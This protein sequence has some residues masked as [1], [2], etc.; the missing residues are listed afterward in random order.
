[1]RVFKHINNLLH[2]DLGSART[3]AGRALLIEQF[4]VLTGQIPVLYGVLIVE[5]LSVS[6]VLPSSLPLWFRFGVPSA[7]LVVSA[8]RMIY[9]IK[10]RRVVPTPERALR[11]LFKTRILASA[12]NACFSIWTLLLFD[13]VDPGSRAPLALLVFMGSIGSAYCLASFPSAARLTLALTALPISLR[14]LFADD[15]LSV[16]IGINNCMLLVPFFR[17]MN[18]NYCD[19]VD[20]IESRTM[21]L[22]EGDRARNA[23]KTARE[24]QANARRIAERFDIAL[25]N[26]S[27]GLCF[28][29]GE[30]R[31]VVCNRR[32]LD[33]YGLAPESVKPGMLLAEIVEL[34]SRA[35]SSPVMSA[36]D[37]MAWRNRIADVNEAS[38][39]IVELADGRVFRICHRPM[40]DHGW[41]ATH[42]DITEQHRAEK[43]L[44]EAKANAERAELTARSAHTRL[45]EAL[46]IVPEGIAILDADDRYVM[47]NKRYAELYADSSQAIIAGMSFEEVLRFG[48]A[49]QQYPDA[50][51]R[52]EEW[53]IE[54]LTRHAQPWS[55]HEQHLSGDRWLRIEERRMEDGG[56]IG[57]RVDITDLKRR[58]A[59]FR[60]LFEENPLPMWVVDVETLQFLAVNA[61]ACQHYGYSPEQM[62]TMTVED[63]RAP[64]ERRML[65]D[66]FRRHGGLHTAKQTRHHVTA[67]GRAIEV[68]IEARPLR[69]N[70]RNAS[71]AV[72]F[73]MTDRKR[74]EQR[75]LH[76][77]CHDILTDL[78]N[79]AALD[80]R[81]A[82]VLQEA[83][84]RGTGF[85]VLCIDLDRF[86]QINDLFG[87]S[88]GDQALREVS[89]RLLAAAQGA[90][91]ARVGGDE[92]IAITDQAPLPSSAELLAKR[93]REALESGILIE[94]HTLELDLSV[95]VAVYPRDGDNA[96]LL[97]ANA[98]AALYRAKAEGRGVIR[99]FSAAMDQ[100]L[101][102]RRALERDLK[103]AVRSGELFLEYQPQRHR[104]G[105][106]IGFEALVRWQHPRHGVIPPTEFISIAEE[107]DLIVEIGD[108]VLREACRR[109]A[110]WDDHLR[111]AVNVSAIQFRRGN[112]Q[113]AVA[114]ALQEAGISPERLELEITESLLIEN[115]A[116]TTQM[117]KGLKKL[118]TRIAL[119]DFGT[120]Y[121]SLSYLQSFPLDRIKIDRSFVATLG[122]A[123]RSLAIVRA[124]I[125]LAH[126]LGLP[127]LA[128]GVETG[129]QLE[130]LIEEGCDEMQGF[131]IGRP[132]RTEAYANLLRRDSAVARV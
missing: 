28:Y 7:L 112:L 84:A 85:A 96:R 71:V 43:A 95:G 29:D 24:E 41:V 38:D 68:A 83:R 99:F 114:M 5:S 47:W 124:V 17:M 87:H 113:R 55:R 102:E 56:S 105:E 104:N 2:L 72:A 120:G 66:E 64:E 22:V 15:T 52:E 50:I 131:L 106:I 53:L 13:S 103:T 25:N 89:Q 76:L 88:T 78:P 61:A 97:F 8:I 34:R 44:A 118:G 26:M 57:V 126:G 74:A 62:L 36:D 79:R 48:L 14:L 127:A 21:L 46:D 90:F 58:E 70:G 32:Y 123:E 59:S 75:I 6:Y 77:A 109:A 20:M 4:R 116:R 27:Q 128:E 93:L 9:W 86:K 16:C 54:R 37:Y 81:F 122:R 45:T 11:H 107:S 3:P 30:Q 94:G 98:D 69:Y 129:E 111:I 115:V 31:L 1:M 80:G 101:R 39:S 33:M 108:W 100:Q 91:L 60:L 18:T 23:E 10:L 63:L 92:F 35:G 82:Q 40:P 51:G 132:R 119:D 73:D 65:R 49:R 121:S 130:I 117:L 12:F 42:D 125:G 67:D 19:L 110:S